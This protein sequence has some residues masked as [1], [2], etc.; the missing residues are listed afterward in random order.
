MDIISGAFE[1]YIEELVLE[2][3][4]PA[5]CYRIAR[6]ME[7][8]LSRLLARRKTA[9]DT[10]VERLDGEISTGVYKAENIGVLIARS[11]YDGISKQ[12]G[13]SSPGRMER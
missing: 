4:P 3:F 1:L 12:S 13:R 11:V 7:A 5:D 2:G 9:P 8:E 6:A 10:N